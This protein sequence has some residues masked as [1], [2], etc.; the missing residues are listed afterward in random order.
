VRCD[1]TAA[2]QTAFPVQCKVHLSCV[3][4]S[5]V[6]LIHLHAGVLVYHHL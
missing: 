5:H 3:T 6:P 2:W 1:P 4:T